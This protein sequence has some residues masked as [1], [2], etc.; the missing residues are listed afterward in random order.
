[1][2]GETV[3]T[4]SDYHV[5]ITP[6][7][8]CKGLYVANQ[9]PDSFEVRELNRGK[10]NVAFNYRIVAKRRAYEGV[11]LAESKSHAESKQRGSRATVDLP[12]LSP[13]TTGNWL[14]KTAQSVSQPGNNGP[15]GQTWKCSGTSRPH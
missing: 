3:N 5:F 11:R 14:A 7:A 1:M 9:G 8:D 13:T 10:A 12:A 6:R 15:A 4:E 2:F